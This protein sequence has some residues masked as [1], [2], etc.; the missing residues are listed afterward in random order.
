MAV[1]QRGVSFSWVGWGDGDAV[2]GDAR[3]AQAGGEFSELVEITVGAAKDRPAGTD[4]HDD[5][6]AGDVSL[7]DGNGAE[8]AE[9]KWIAVGA[10]DP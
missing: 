7:S 1:L 8:R 2:E 9:R 5:F 6:V 3:F 10:A 4:P